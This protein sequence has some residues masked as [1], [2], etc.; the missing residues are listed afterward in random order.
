MKKN[1]NP[2]NSALTEENSDKREAPLDLRLLELLI[3]KII[4]KLEENSYEPKV[5][6]ALKAIQIKQKIAQSSEAERTFWQLLEEIKKSELAESDKPEGLE[7]QILRIIIELKSQVKRGM[8]P[9]KTITDAFNQGKSEESQL[10]YQRIGRV[11]SAMGFTKGK[12]G[13]NSAILWD[14][15]NIKHL[16]EIYRLSQTQETQ[17]RQETHIPEVNRE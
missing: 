14:Q 15:E 17:E 9:V 2:K 1:P 4:K 10:T 12:V 7:A 6:D 11:L 3:R 8:L 16:A 5:Q 13:N